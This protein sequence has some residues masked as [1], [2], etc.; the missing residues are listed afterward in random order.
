MP[1][2]RGEQV[3]GGIVE[4]GANLR[5]RHSALA[6]KEDLLA[7]QL[8]LFPI[9]AIAVGAHMRRPEQA[10]RIMMMQRPGADPRG[11]GKLLDGSHMLSPHHPPPCRG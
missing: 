9:I 7:P 5:Q 10:H 6:V 8:L 11:F 4:H 1:A 3:E 2:R